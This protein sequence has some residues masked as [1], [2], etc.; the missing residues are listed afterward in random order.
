MQV[1]DNVEEFVL[2]SEYCGQVIVAG[3]VTQLPREFL[4]NPVIH[5]Q[6]LDVSFLLASLHTHTLLVEVDS[7]GH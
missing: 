1:T 2:L 7:A 6:P 5:S 3:S 4:L